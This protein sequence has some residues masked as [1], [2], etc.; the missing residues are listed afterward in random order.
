ME[1]ENTDLLCAVQLRLTELARSQNSH[2]FNHV[3]SF[4][5]CDAEKQIK[6]STGENNAAN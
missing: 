5:K 6:R 3:E 4:W 2:Y 1:N